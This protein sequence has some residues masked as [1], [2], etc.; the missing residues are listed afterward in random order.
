MGTDCPPQPGCSFA[1]ENN[2][3]IANYLHNGLFWHASCTFAAVPSGSRSHVHSRLG[4]RK[5]KQEKQ[6]MNVITFSPTPRILLSSDNHRFISPL[7]NALLKAGYLVD[8]ASDYRHLELLWQ[9]L[10]HD[11]VLLEVTYPGS[12]ESATEAALRIKSQDAQ[13]FIGYLADAVLQMS[14]L[15]GDAIFSRDAQKLPGALRDALDEQS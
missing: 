13:Q 9:Q 10:H 11:V 15:T 2:L 7:R 14:G 8:L 5:K 6:L 3:F 1:K 12:V 4:I